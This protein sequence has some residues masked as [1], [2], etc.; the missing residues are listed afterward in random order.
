MGKRCYS[1]EVAEAYMKR[2]FDQCCL[3]ACREKVIMA[4]II[5]PIILNLSDCPKR[6]T[7][8]IQLLVISEMGHKRFYF[9]LFNL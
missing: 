9:N 7:N 1:L 4:L 5:P 2:G 6:P 3:A 8:A